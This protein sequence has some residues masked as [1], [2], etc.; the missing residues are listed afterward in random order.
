MLEKGSKTA[1]IIPQRAI[2]LKIALNLFPDF[3]TFFLAIPRLKYLIHMKS[4]D[5]KIPTRNTRPTTYTKTILK[6]IK[7]IIILKSYRKGVFP[8]VHQFMHHQM[9]YLFIIKPNFDKNKFNF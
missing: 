3:P 5:M 1:R 8:A 7:I 9:T 2:S 6:D 4:M